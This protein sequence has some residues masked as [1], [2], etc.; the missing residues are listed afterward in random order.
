M[1]EKLAEL[2]PVFIH[3][4]I[5]LFFAF[6]ILEFLNLFYQENI[7]DGINF[8]TLIA[9]ILFSVVA[10]LTGNQAKALV[11]PLLNVKQAELAEILDLHETAATLSLWI[12]TGIFFLKYYLYAKRKFSIRWK[13][14]ITI[15][16]FIGIVTIF[17]T[18]LLGG[19]LV[20]EFGVGTK[21][22]AK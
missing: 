19:K 10:V 16:A 13:I 20:Y 15:M 18:G 3:F 7:I 1:I 21:F 4:P 2:H 22:F 14:F 12:F 6:F 11:I 9:G 17:E 8:I 5:V